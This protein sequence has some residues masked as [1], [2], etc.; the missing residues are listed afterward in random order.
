MSISPKFIGPESPAPQPASSVENNQT[1]FSGYAGLFERLATNADTPMDGRTA[2]PS[3][4]PPRS[5]SIRRR[6][7]YAGTTK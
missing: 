1:A 3:M 2:R 7:K 5:G 6:S 4:D